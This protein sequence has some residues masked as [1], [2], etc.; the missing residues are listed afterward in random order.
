MPPA[1]I[2][3]HISQPANVVS[4]LPLGV[5]LDRQVRQLGSDLGDGS[6][7]DIADFCTGMNG[8]FG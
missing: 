1:P 3:S 5:V 8:E 7:W 2:A 4:H 6:G